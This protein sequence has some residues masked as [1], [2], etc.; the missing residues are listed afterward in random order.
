M[1]IESSLDIEHF[2]ACGIWIFPILFVFFKS[3]FATMKTHENTSLF[4]L[5]FGH[6]GSLQAPLDHS[7]AGRSLSTANNVSRKRTNPGD[8]IT[9]LDG[10]PEATSSF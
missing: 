9:A 3:V 6:D 5:S 8:E 7:C 4:L 1:T 2:V 10:M